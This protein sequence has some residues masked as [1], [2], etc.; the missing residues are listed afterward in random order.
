[1]SYTEKEI[2]EELDSNFN[3]IPSSFYPKGEE[4]DIIYSFFLD[5]E[6]G[7]CYVANSKIHLYA[8]KDRWAI[9]FEK[10][11]Y[12]TRANRAEIYL[13]YVGNCINYNVT[14][15]SERNYIS[16]MAVIVLITNIEFARIQNNLGSEMEQFELINP[17]IKEIEI[18][19][20]KIPIEHDSSIY[21]KHGIKVRDYDNSK[22]LIGF[23][24]VVRFFAE[25]NPK[26]IQA[27]EI[28][29]KQYIPNDIPKILTIDQFN[30]LSVYQEEKIASQHETYQLIAKVLTAK[31]ADFWKPTLK[32]NN[33]WSN[34]ESGNL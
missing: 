31:N 13:H 1:M 2:L 3:E 7:Y 28:E 14:K 27:T 12:N 32:P 8:D 15:H 9:V 23:E 16:N 29:I 22:K 24:D 10:N 26:I 4:R 21:E 20:L 18:R 30:H 5:L 33:H 11:G 34:W 19:G 6:H 17:K 25:T